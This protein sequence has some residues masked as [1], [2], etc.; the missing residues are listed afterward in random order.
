MK[1]P[2]EERSGLSSRSTISAFPLK[3]STWARRT[4]H[5]LSGS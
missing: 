5:T 2:V 3:T 4:V 1:L